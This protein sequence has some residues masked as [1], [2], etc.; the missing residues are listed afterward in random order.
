MNF[1]EGLR[2]AL[3]S[4]VTNPL[5]SFLTLLGI[6]MGVTAIIAVVAVING[7]NLYVQE[8]IIKL[9]P[10][11]FAPGLGSAAPSA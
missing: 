1:A 6:V 2:V 7:L 9:G 5:R 11:S 3:E 8:K 10:A 4:L